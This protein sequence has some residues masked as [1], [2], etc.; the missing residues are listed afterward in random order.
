MKFI[1]KWTY[2]YTGKCFKVTDNDNYHIIMYF[3]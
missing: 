2:D 3:C 1:Q